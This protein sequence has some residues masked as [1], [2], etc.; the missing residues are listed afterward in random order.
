[1]TKQEEVDNL[2][3]QIQLRDKRIEE[4]ESW[5]FY[6]VEKDN[7]ISYGKT[8]EKI[9]YKIEAEQMNGRFEAEQKAGIEKDARINNLNQIIKF[10]IDPSILKEDKIEQKVDT[11]YP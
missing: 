7:P 2:K 9:Y 3:A 8:V 6:K 1:M 5:A 10:L 4:L 11:I